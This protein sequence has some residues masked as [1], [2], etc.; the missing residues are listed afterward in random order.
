MITACRR[1]PPGSF[2]LD[3][4]LVTEAD[5]QAGHLPWICSTSMSNFIRYCGVY[6]N[7]HAENA[8][9]TA[10]FNHGGPIAE[11]PGGAVSVTYTDQKA[12]DQA[13]REAL[14]G[15]IYELDYNYKDS[16]RSDWPAFKASGYRTI[17]K[18]EA[19]YVYLRVKGANASNL[20]YFLE[21]PEFGAN[22]IRL[23]STVNPHTADFGSAVHQIYE[24]F[25]SLSGARS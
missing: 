20:Y 7:S 25:L 14:E 15:C 10:M 3:L 18:F 17:R 11:I 22:S 13:V 4:P 19:D 9:V 21:S 2:E 23:I 6:C 12:M 1:L 8:I 16:K 24:Q 5:A